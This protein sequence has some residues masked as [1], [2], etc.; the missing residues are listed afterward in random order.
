MGTYYAN[1]PIIAFFLFFSLLNSI[2]NKN[3]KWL[4]E[5]ASVHLV[6]AR[7]LVIRLIVAAVAE[8]TL[9]IKLGGDGIL[10][11]SDPDKGLCPPIL[12]SLLIV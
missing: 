4:T 11:R 3:S 10:A 12:F 1:E 9:P 2:T 6:V 8:G 5:H 7:L